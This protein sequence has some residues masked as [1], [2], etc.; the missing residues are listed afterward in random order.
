MY[1]LRFSAAVWKQHADVKYDL[2]LFVLLISLLSVTDARLLCML[3]S[4]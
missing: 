4:S 3:T 2:N 1:I